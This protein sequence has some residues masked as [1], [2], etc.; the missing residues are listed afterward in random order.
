MSQAAS[1]FSSLTPQTPIGLVGAGTMGRGI[2]QVMLQGGHPVVLVDTNAAV[3]P[4]AKESI[5]AS[6][7]KAAKKGK[8]T[9]DPQALMQQLT[10]ATELAALAPVGVVIEAIV[11]DKAIKQSLFRTLEGIV[12]PSCLLASNTSSIAITALSGGLVHPQRVVGLHFFNP[13]PIMPLV[14][15]IAGKA[16]DHSLPEA[17]VQ[18]M[19]ILGKQPVVAKDTPGFIVNRVARPFYGEALRLLSEGIAD[20]ETIDAVLTDVGGFAMGPFRLMDL[21]GVDVNLAV[22]ESVY[23]AFY[24]EPRFRPNPVQRQYVDAGWHGQKTGRGFYSYAKEDA[25]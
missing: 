24:Q 13:A 18:W 6:L 17:L 23:Q 20:I 1:D 19:T 16:T 3:L 7:E 10:V 2:A 22:S 14:E 4:Q 9:A 12:A 11:E 8:L 5:A 25:S 15:V 21:I